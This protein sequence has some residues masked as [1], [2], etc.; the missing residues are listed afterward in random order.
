MVNIYNASSAPY[1]DCL[2]PCVLQNNLLNE[3]W[4]PVYTIIHVGYIYAASRPGELSN[5][6][7]I[8]T[9]MLYL[10]FIICLVQIGIYMYSEKKMYI[11]R[12]RL[13]SFLTN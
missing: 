5:Y 11:I 12:Y 7:L 9:W 8:L 13:V 4:F 1:Y 3:T 2:L 10:N 6:R